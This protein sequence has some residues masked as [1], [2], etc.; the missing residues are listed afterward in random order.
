MMDFMKRWMELIV[1]P[2]LVVSTG[3]LSCVGYL[4]SVPSL[5]QLGILSAS[6]PLPI[7]FTDRNGD[8]HNF[9]YRYTMTVETIQGETVTVPM[10]L[11][12]MH[13]P[14][15]RIV[16]YE[17]AAIIWPRSSF[18]MTAM[19][20]YICQ[21]EPLHRDLDGMQPNRVSLDMYGPEDD[22]SSVQEITIVCRQS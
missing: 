17:I 22:Q 7:P 12:D 4:F 5:Q 14:H 16:M 13:G 20:S 21:A 19:L 3:L 6:A 2:T 1:L 10:R 15:R 11:S 18:L 8:E 9:A